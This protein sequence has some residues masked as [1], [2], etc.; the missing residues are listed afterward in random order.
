LIAVGLHGVQRNSYAIAWIA[1]GT[2]PHRHWMRGDASE[3]AR[4]S[5]PVLLLPGT[6]GTADVAK[7]DNP[8]VEIV[9]RAARADVAS[10]Q[11]RERQVRGIRFAVVTVEWHGSRSLRCGA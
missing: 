9:S 3:H 4:A 6:A 5:A 11:S 2:M 7:Q 8:T 10:P 1:S